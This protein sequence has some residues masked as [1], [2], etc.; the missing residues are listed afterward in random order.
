LPRHL[1]LTGDF[2]D[3]SLAAGLAGQVGLG[4]VVGEIA[5]FQQLS[6]A[7][8]VLP[9]IKFHRETGGPS[10]MRCHP[11]SS[12]VNGVIELLRGMRSANRTFR[13][14]TPFVLAWNSTG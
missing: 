5:K 10:L 13:E 4:K 7:T 14:S 3:Y 6:E 9:C 12:R 11:V 2:T 8:T 1:P